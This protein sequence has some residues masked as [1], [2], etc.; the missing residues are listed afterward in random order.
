M[1]KK[2]TSLHAI[3]N[4]L[5]DRTNSDIQRL[6]VLEQRNDILTSRSNAIEK[7]IL[8][9]SRNMQK[10]MLNIETKNKRMEE[11]I[12]KNDVML[13]EVVKQMK[14][15]A[16]TSKITELEQLI[17]I[18]NPLKSQFVTKEEVQRMIGKKQ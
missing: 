10:I 15:L 14:K 11:R 4:E 2:P 6:R 5:V 9:I 1:A 18:Y 3:I 17:E 8:N 16:T 13:R 7:E 12:K